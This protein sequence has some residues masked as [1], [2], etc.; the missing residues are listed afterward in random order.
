[1][2][3]RVTT[4]FNIRQNALTAVPNTALMRTINALPKPEPMS[5]T[6]GLLCLKKRRKKQGIVC[7]NLLQNLKKLL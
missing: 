6:I 7:L 4:A 5:G 3:I 2:K 1:M